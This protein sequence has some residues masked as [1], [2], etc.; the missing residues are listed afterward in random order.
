MSTCEHKD[1]CDDLC[2]C[3]CDTCQEYYETQW[4]KHVVER[5]L[6]PVCGMP[7]EMTLEALKAEHSTHFFQPCDIC[8]PVFLAI[9][10][11]NNMC[12]TCQQ[13]LNG[14]TCKDCFCTDEPYTC[15]CR[16][17]KAYRKSLDKE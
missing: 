1:A 17:C 2:T 13:Y 4:G 9:M 10:K 16:Q 14:E 11:Q 15:E 8:K 6:C 7:L 5:N 3:T 12:P